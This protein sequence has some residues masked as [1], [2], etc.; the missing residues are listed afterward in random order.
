MLDNAPMTTQTKQI[1]LHE[2]LLA[3]GQAFK[4]AYEEAGLS[5][6]AVAAAVPLDRSA[7]TKIEKGLR[8]PKF[9]TLLKMAR[10]AGTTPAAL[11]GA[12]TRVSSTAARQAQSAD[13]A[14]AHDQVRGQQS[15]EAAARHFGESLRRTREAVDGWMTQED[16]AFYAKVDRSAVSGY[17]TGRVAPSLATIFKLAQTLKVGAAVLV[18]AVELAGGPS[19]R[20]ERVGPLPASR[21]TRERPAAGRGQRH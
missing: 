7:L 12:E 3:F 16:L 18:D 6:R 11:L 20:L 2:Q 10:A 4:R 17:E 21:R 15:V 13:A 8:G 5:K 9:E 14:G 19:S 1:D